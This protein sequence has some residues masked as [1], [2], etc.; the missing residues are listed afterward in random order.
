MNGGY[1][2][3][4]RRKLFQTVA[5]A[6][7]GSVLTGCKGKKQR[8]RAPASPPQVLEPTE[9]LPVP[10]RK[11][12]KT[13]VEVPCLALGGNQDLMANQ[14]VLRNAPLWGV[15][16]WDTAHNYGESEPGIGKYL[17]QNPDARK[18]LF[19]ATKASYA[20]TPEELEDRLQ[21]SLKN[22]NTDYI[23]LYFGV[24]ICSDPAQMTGELKQWA[25]NAKRQK[26]I[27]FLGVSTHQ[28]MPN[29][30]STAAKLDWID[31][32][33]TIYNFRLM[34]YEPLSAAID[35]CYKA[36]I[37]LVAMKT[38]GSSVVTVQAR[39]LVEHF[40]Q[41]GFSKEQAMVKAILQDERFTTVCLGMTNVAE[42][43]AGVAAAQGPA[44][45]SDADMK[46]LRQYA[47]A[48]STGYCA[49]C[50]HICNSALPQALR[51]GRIADIMRYLMYY[52][53][54]GRHDTA[55]D[56]F[57]QIPCRVRSRLLDIDYSVAEARCPQHL[58]I[59]KLVAEAV[60]K[61]TSPAPTMV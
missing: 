50:A 5:A 29:V 3:I 57:A 53:S 22:L 52:N 6:G 13:D 33:M 38:L 35:A 32:V 19:L 55:R 8:Q 30:L 24:H 59:A 40:Q 42:L 39:Q 12:G 26:R 4:S 14:I 43:R 48:T 46:A 16:Y 20:K 2:E 58:P 11:L 51:P 28:N 34:Q 37:G 25:E 23:D 27:R 54:Y 17:A 21:T 1:S 36:G 47:D 60:N 44:V 45:L 10:K 41:R 15:T 31:V 61:L 18:N 56:L 49:G 9:N 7:A